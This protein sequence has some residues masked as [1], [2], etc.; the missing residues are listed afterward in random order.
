MLP[1]TANVSV[2]PKARQ[3]RA[4]RC[5][6]RDD[7]GS[8]PAPPLP[9]VAESENNSARI[10]GHGLVALSSPPVSESAGGSASRTIR[11]KT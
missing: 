8:H 6:S 7:G 1:V 4:S 10:L 5:G 3:Q 9:L 2:A 11:S